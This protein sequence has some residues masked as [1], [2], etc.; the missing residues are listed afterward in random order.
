VL[1]RMVVSITQSLYGNGSWQPCRSEMRVA[2]G[3]DGR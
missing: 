3:K 2:A 1:R